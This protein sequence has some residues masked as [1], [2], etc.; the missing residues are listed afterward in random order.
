MIVYLSS[1]FPPYKFAAESYIYVALLILNMV[2]V[3]RSWL[4]SIDACLYSYGWRLKALDQKT[5]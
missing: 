2:D 4:Y 3:A 5:L 1:F